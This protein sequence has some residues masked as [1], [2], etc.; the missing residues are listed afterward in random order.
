MLTFGVCLLS[1]VI[2][3]T[4]FPSPEKEHVLGFR[5]SQSPGQLELLLEKHTY[6]RFEQALYS[7]QYIYS[8][9]QAPY[10]VPRIA[11]KADPRA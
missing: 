8:S 7:F 11:V 9:L 3:V 2:V 1:T 4:A 10:I 5:L 6:V